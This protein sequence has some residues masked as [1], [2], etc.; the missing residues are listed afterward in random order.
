MK[1]EKEKRV[2]REAAAAAA[3]AYAGVLTLHVRHDVI[4]GGE[5]LG[6]VLPFLLESV[7][8]YY[9]ATPFLFAGL[10]VFYLFALR[11]FKSRK[12][13]RGTVIYSLTVA[14][15]FGLFMPLGY[16]MRITD[17]LS[18]LLYGPA[19]LLRTALTVMGYTCLFFFGEI[20]LYSLID[21]A[22]SGRT[23]P[24]P[25][26][27]DNRAGRGK[28]LRCFAVLLLLYLPY[29][30][31]SYPGKMTGDT[32]LQILEFYG[33]M[34]YFPTR[35]MAEG[36]S[37]WYNA[38]PILH[39]LCLG[40]CLELGKRLFSS[41]NVGMFLFGS[42]QVLFLLWALCRCLR[43]M[44]LLGAG[45]RTLLAFGA[46]YVI[47]PVIHSFLLQIT[48]DVPFSVF[49]L[50]FLLALSRLLDADRGRRSWALLIAGC[51]GVLLLRNEGILLLLPALLLAA[52]SGAGL[53][54]PMAVTA[55]CCL[56]FYLCW[57]LFLLPAA[58]VNPGSKREV[59]SLPFQM[60]AR[61]LRDRGE[62]VTEEEAEAIGAV[63]DVENLAELY[64]P[65]LSDPVKNT[66]RETAGGEEL[67]NYFRVWLEMGLKH[68][69]TYL[70]AFLAN[71]DR[72]FS[73]FENRSELYT[74]GKSTERME[75]TNADARDLGM[76]LHHPAALN[77][78][79]S[80]YESLFTLI[81]GLPLIE[82]LKSSAFAVLTLLLWLGYC[83]H[84]RCLR[85][86]V[87]ET[88]LLVILCNLILGPCNGQYVRYS[89]P[90]FFCLPFV[91]FW[92]AR[93]MA[94]EKEKGEM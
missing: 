84:R 27:R 24:P 35:P 45:R 18:V 89:Y 29:I 85:A 87:L 16:A 19:R 28:L 5:G 73:L 57:N 33:R 61:Y 68:P 31:L 11:S 82:L 92:G 60:T 36:A 59:L 2:T 15:L 4:P 72:Y 65:I 71:K 77:R 75:K 23:A 37:H 63:L 80:A 42:V 1:R 58:H 9:F 32:R 64:D 38:H 21:R 69:S 54:K 25:R 52:L 47:S 22:L 78:A 51:L 81:T 70:E 30:V 43:E 41:Y 50:L 14:A 67:Q 74:Y 88:P 62:E 39:T 76:D 3:L 56:C 83:V 46:Y 20:L 93:F 40:G 48:K 44:E 91:L 34:N 6:A 94:Q 66:F 10:F 79:R 7:T 53:R 55:G 17:G 26:L 49:L 8:D 86:A 90:L 12:W 13:G